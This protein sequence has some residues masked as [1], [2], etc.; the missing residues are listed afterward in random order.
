[1]MMMVVVVVVV[2]AVVMMTI[3]I[4]RAVFCNRTFVVVITSKLSGAFSKTT[5]KI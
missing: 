1:M 4:W 5:D 2:V 3:I